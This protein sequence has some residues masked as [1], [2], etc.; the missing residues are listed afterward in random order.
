MM[1]LGVGAV[2]TK[3]YVDDV[4]STHLYTANGSTR[5]IV[6]GIDLSGEGGLVWIKART[7]NNQTHNLYDTERGATK[8][9]A[10]DV[11][12][13]ETTIT[14]TLTAFN[15]NGFTLGVDVQ[16]WGVNWGTLT[17]TSWTFRKAPGF[18]DVVKYT[19]NGNNRTIAHSLGSVPGLI[20]VKRTSANENWA[21]YHR[22]L[23]ATKGMELDE[24]AAA[25]DSGEY[26]WNDTEPTSSVF[27]VGTNNKV[28]GN[29]D[30][31]VAYLFAGGASTAA[32]ARSVEFDGSNDYLSL[33]A[34]SDI[35]V[36]T[37]Y[38]IECWFKADALPG[39]YNALFGQWTGTGTY[40]YLVE[41]VGTEL[42]LYG[43]ASWGGHKV[44]GSP[45]L[46][47]WHHLA[48]S[49][50]GT[51]TR[52][53]LNGIQT[54]ADFDMG[55][56]S[57]TSDFTIGGFVAT[58][59]WFDGEISNLRIVNGTAVYT[60]SFRPPTEPLTNIT[61]TK[62]LCCNN[63]SQAGSTV[64]PGTITN[65]GSTASTDSPFYDPAGFVFGDAGDQNVISTGS[66]I[67]NGSATG[68]EINL[69]W[70]P[71]Y[72]LVKNASIGSTEWYIYDSMRG[73]PTD[74]DDTVLKANANDAEN[75][76]ANQYDLTPTGFKVKIDSASVNGNG[77]TIIY[78]AIRRP[79]GYCGKPPSLGTDVFAMDTG[80]SSTTIPTY[81]SG[82]PVDFALRKNT[83]TAADWCAP[84]RLT[85]GTFVKP[86]STAA[87][88]T[89]SDFIF[90][91][92]AGWAKGS[93]QNSNLQSW[94]WKRGKGFDCLI[95]QGT[96]STQTIAH[97]LGVT[98]ELIFIKNRNRA[99]NSGATAVWLAW[100]KDLTSGSYSNIPN[101]NNFLELNTTEGVGTGDYFNSTAPTSSV[102]S[103]G[104]TSSKW[105]VRQNLSGDSYLMLLFS[106]VDGISK[107]GY[108]DGSSSTQTITTGFQPRFLIIKCSSNAFENWF[109][110]DTTRGW[111]SGN[112]EYLVMNTD[113]AQVGN[114]DIGA[115][116]STGFTVTHDGGWNY[117]GRKY[118]YYA[119][120]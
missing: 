24:S 96:G 50:E 68:P 34:H 51:T 119:H 59:G 17:E 19:G 30:S 58:A 41:Y 2:A 6:N 104:T 37:N 103:I 25:G 110:L 97:S 66:Y 116:T 23:G 36:G 5:S 73:I 46:G 115:P 52:V 90:D 83:T 9:L 15:S 108:F 10:S 92:N 11:A 40:G 53:F 91:S 1:L 45:G 48:I 87:Q 76:S 63:S 43:P 86:N 62:L 55:T 74:G 42:R 67:G 14:D 32:T 100:H 89:D 75:T 120:A 3:T 44:I 64:T 105:D 113:A 12:D 111:G 56:I 65:N 106:S 117:Q 80:N 99:V 81:D 114:A 21:V 79:D 78:I 85:S 57:A 107:V 109:V 8:M 7:G 4:F 18:F 112:D 71:Q 72:L 39:T 94:M 84:A 54:V 47:Q 26:Y 20:L 13:A 28:N 95:Y 49:K 35:E 38:T 118:I 31:Y 82:F 101:T 16:G 77:N 70:E 102:V 27:S 98:P 29:G 88:L 22:S 61:N 60:S 93:G 69:G 33:A